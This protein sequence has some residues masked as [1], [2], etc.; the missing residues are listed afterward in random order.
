MTALP[1]H[2]AGTSEVGKQKTIQVRVKDHH[3]NLIDLSTKTLTASAQSGSDTPIT[4]TFAADSDQTEGNGLGIG[5]VIITAAQSTT[6]GAQT[7]VLRTYVGESSGL[8]ELLWEAA[9]TWEAVA[10]LA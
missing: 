4:P 8:D 3:G 6:G 7:W 2:Q 9:F 1:L 10:A 5:N